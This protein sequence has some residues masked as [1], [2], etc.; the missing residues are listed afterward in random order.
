MNVNIS[1]FTLTNIISKTGLLEQT[2]FLQTDLP[3]KI[4]LA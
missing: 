4:L 2:L 1:R 3:E